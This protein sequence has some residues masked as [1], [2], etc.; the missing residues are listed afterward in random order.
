[1]HPKFG[2]G[3]IEEIE[4]KNGGVN[5]HIRFKEGLKKIDQ[6]WLLQTKYQKAGK[7]N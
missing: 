3:D 4:L 7:P 1:M 6:K 5:L 2:T